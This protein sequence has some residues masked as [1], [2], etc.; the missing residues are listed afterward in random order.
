[1]GL[2]WVLGLAVYCLRVL[3]GWEIVLT[4]GL[5]SSPFLGLPYN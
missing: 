1:M 5:L 4:H 2:A 3:S